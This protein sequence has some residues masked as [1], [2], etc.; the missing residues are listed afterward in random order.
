MLIGSQH[1][2][3]Q[4]NHLGPFE[5]NEGE[6][7]GQKQRLKIL[8]P[9][10]EH[11]SGDQ[12]LGKWDE[13]RGFPPY[14]QNLRSGATWELVGPSGHLSSEGYDFYCSGRVRDVEVLSDLHIRVVSA[15][16]GLYDIVT[17][18]DGNATAKNLTS[19]DVLSTW[20]GT[21]ATDPFDENIIL[22]GTGEPGVR[23]GTGLW[24]S[25]DK[26]VAWSHIPLNGGVGMGAFDEMEFTNQEGKVWTSGSD[27]VFF[28]DN[29]GLTWTQKWTG[30]CQGMVVFPNDAK[31]VL[32][33]DLYRGIY[34]TTD[35]GDNW[36]L[37][38][39]GLPT[40]DFARIE[41]SNCKSQPNVIYALYTTISGYTMGIYKSIDSGE[42]WTRCTILNANG[43]KDIDY[44]WGMAGYCSFISVSSV[45][46]NHVISG[47]GWYI[48][49]NDGTNF[50]G[51]EAGQHTD[52]HTGGW[53]KDGTVAY[54]G[55]D[56]GIYNTLFDQKW[57]WNHKINRLPITQYG[58]IAVAPTNPQAIIGGT[59]DNGLVYY[60]PKVKKWFYSGGD[61]GGVAYDYYNEEIV[62]GTNGV[63]FGQPYLYYN[64]YKKGP[65]AAGWIPTNEGL[66]PSDQWGRLVR[67][68]R[69]NPP[70]VYTQADNK[71]YYSDDNG[72]IWNKFY[73][74]DIAI[75]AISSMRVSQGEYPKIYVSGN[76]SDTSNCMVLD[77]AEWEWKN[78]SKGLPVRTNTN[79][80]TEPHVYISENPSFPDRVYALM[81]GF[82]SHIKGRVL[83]KSEDN[84]SNWNNISGNLPEVPYT[85]MMEHP[86][87]DKI[88]VVGTDGFGTFITDNGGKNWQKWDDE[89]PKGALISD[90]DF[91]K[92]SN[93]SIYL[94]A[95]TYGNSI[96]RRMLPNT[97]IVSTNDI[98]TKAFINNIT[99]ATIQDGQFFV[100]FRDELSTN[101]SIKVCSMEGK[102]IYS[103]SL[104]PGSK[105][106]SFDAQHFPS[107]MYVI[108]LHQHN[109]V[110]G[111]GRIVKP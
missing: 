30:N 83:F 75:N 92:F 63:N 107:G 37:K 44:H 110:I 71:V 23:G 65:S 86:I 38:T 34:K 25:A 82:G 58:T 20:G 45:N 16:G 106:Y 101:A 4:A 68:D 67:T 33:G 41:L 55:N 54:Y 97:E 109:K 10:F 96:W 49:S 72:E 104:E 18:P 81:R 88:L 48:Y 42:N 28:S 102:C 5:K 79:D 103:Q 99:A 22:Y 8:N 111:T 56:G 2:V 47:G 77:A 40:G 70:M 29:S 95:S 57:N 85:V 24:R 32:V 90:F 43:E 74:D 61:G 84:G 31:T 59:Q 62:Y 27:G 50:Y 14:S 21:V 105:N 26:G 93:D 36:I 46:P 60:V 3:G 1:M 69:N 73:T 13:L 39:S 53:S 6:H 76:G 94:V 66:D 98:N 12:V 7:L 35:G 15:S 17:E 87:N 89:L 64:Y 78:I 9:G 80:Y 51:P 108:S 52:F 19:K 91:Q 100:S 11:L